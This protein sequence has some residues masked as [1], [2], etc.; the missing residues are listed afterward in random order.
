[1][2]SPCHK[3]NKQIPYWIQSSSI[4]PVSLF[5]H[6]VI[7]NQFAKYMFCLSPVFLHAINAQKQMILHSPMP[8]F[9]LLIKII[10]CSAPTWDSSCNHAYTVIS[11]AGHPLD[12]A[13]SITFSICGNKSSVFSISRCL[14]ES[15]EL[16]WLPFE[17]VGVSVGYSHWSLINDQASVSHHDSAGTKRC[18]KQ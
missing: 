18:S 17:C 4:E 7:L 3:N 8:W 16:D 5:F 13:I 2:C 9:G 10:I 11:V 15:I 12:L 6:S 14:A 1:M